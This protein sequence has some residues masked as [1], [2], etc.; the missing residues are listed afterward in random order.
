MAKWK[1]AFLKSLDPEYDT[2]ESFTFGPPATEAE[3][4]ALETAI[5][6]KLPEDLR[7]LLLEFNGI[8][9]SDGETYFFDTTE[10]P[11][12]AEYYREWDWPTDMLLEC[13]S[14]ILYV[15]Q[16]NGFSEMWGVAVKPF[17]SF[18][19]GQVVA[20]NHDEIAYAEEPDELFVVPYQSLI[21]LVEA[22]FKTTE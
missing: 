21:K 19:Y 17:G 20:F 11:T 15:C 6:E 3:L 7:E 12:A 5:S 1:A 14:N 22:D 13:S 8:K 9:D 18:Q 10:M 16:E 2:E 4:S